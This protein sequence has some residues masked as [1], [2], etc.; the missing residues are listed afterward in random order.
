VPQTLQMDSWFLGTLGDANDLYR[1][2]EGGWMYF[3]TVPWWRLLEKG[4]RR[5][6]IAS[7]NLDVCE[8]ES[9]E[10]KARREASV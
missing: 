4:L 7:H 9:L 10:A 5:I 2:I 8:G 6:P 1:L 3:A